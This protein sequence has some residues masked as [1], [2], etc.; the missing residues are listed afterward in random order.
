[1]AINRIEEYLRQDPRM[2]AFFANL[3]QQSAKA[4]TGTHLGGLASL[5]N[6]LVRT[7]TMGKAGERRRDLAKALTEGSKNKTKMIDAVKEQSVPYTSFNDG[8]MEGEGETSLDETFSY[9][10]IEGITSRET[11]FTDDTG[12][13]IGTPE[14]RARIDPNSG[15]AFGRSESLRKLLQKFPESESIQRALLINENRL[16]DR[17]L[18][19]MSNRIKSQNAILTRDDKREY[20]AKVAKALADAKLTAA[21]KKA[22][23]DPAQLRLYKFAVEEQGYEGSFTDWALRQKMAVTGISAGNLKALDPSDPYWRNKKKTPVVPARD[24]NE[25][26]TP[27]NPVSSEIDLTRFAPEQMD[28]Q[29]NVFSYR[30]KVTGEIIPTALMGNNAGANS[31]PPLRLM[32]D[33]SQT[34]GAL[35][36]VPVGQSQTGG[37]LG[38]VPV[39]QSR[40]SDAL[41]QSDTG[42]ALGQM[43]IAQAEML[44]KQTGVPVEE[45]L[46]RSQSQTDGALGGL[47]N[48]EMLQMQNTPPQRAVESTSPDLTRFQP[49]GMDDQGNVFSYK[50]TATG[51]IVPANMVNN[52]AEATPIGGA[53]FI[54]GGKADVARK[55]KIQKD[56]EI[57]IK[58][59]TLE[60]NQLKEKRSKEKTD[61]KLKKNRENTERIGGTVIQDTGR[62][63]ELAKE[64]FLATGLSADIFGVI[65][66]D[67]I[68]PALGD[69]K[70]IKDLVTS[71][72]GN[73]SIEQIMAMK[74][75]SETGGALGQIPVAQQQIMMG[76]LGVLDAGQRG[77]I[78]IDNLKRVQN[79]YKDMVHGS[80]EQLA[81][82]V[83]R[84][85]ITAD[86]ARK[87]SVRQVLSFDEQ[88]NKKYV[89][90]PGTTEADIAHTM[91]IYRMSRGDV[92]QRLT[93]LA[94]PR[95][96]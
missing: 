25:K 60:L 90:P 61:R 56:L 72:K 17:N 24:F 13:M 81:E 5:G 18:A 41:N 80:P 33:P 70:A 10:P 36:Q 86:K 1:M 40:L 28:D 37:A 52:N 30:D 55:K 19:L 42:G 4:N 74:S 22:S 62:A 8:M 78:V 88:G 44:S 85:A 54:P 39:G 46:R 49:A 68:S 58:E 53:T 69:A 79:L 32:P 93:D 35:G 23:Q 84:G 71:I 2:T 94:K 77:N 7:Y 87:L 16:D 65:N 83:R 21:I 82:L 76:L 91:R 45:I 47:S 89:I 95:T 64:N 29:G 12:K 96:P 51:E 43:P 14:A 92:L 66:L 27:A 34:G 57:R 48:S 3:Q 15:A 20:D 63:L 67:G 31:A 50:D 73:I 6:T 11:G 38:Q 59:N 75:A 9:D 26:K